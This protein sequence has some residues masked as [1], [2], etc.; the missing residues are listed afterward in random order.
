MYGIFTYIYQTYQPNVGRYTIHWYYMGHGKQI[1]NLNVQPGRC[2]IYANHLL[3]IGT[4]PRLLLSHLLGKPPKMH[5]HINIY[6]P[7]I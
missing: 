1:T 6:T 4:G 7:E 3:S 2:I 5:L